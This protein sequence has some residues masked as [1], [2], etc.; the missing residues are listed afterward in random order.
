MKR[1]ISDED[2]LNTGKN[3]ENNLKNAKVKSNEI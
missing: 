3:S 2:F 1:Y